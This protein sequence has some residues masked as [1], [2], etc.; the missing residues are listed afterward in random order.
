MGKVV[1]Q[2]SPLNKNIE[3]ESG[4]NL[5]FELMRNEVPVASSCYG[6]GICGKCRVTVLEGLE[7]LPPPSAHEDFL[8]QKLKMSDKER[9]SCQIQV[10]APLKVTTKYW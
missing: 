10:T 9:L 7:N 3:C 8:K 6:E 2:T 1:V 4:D 5:M